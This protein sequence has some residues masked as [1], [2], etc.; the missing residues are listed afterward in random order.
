MEESVDIARL[1]PSVVVFECDGRCADYADAAPQGE[2]AGMRPPEN[3]RLTVQEFPAKR[4]KK[5]H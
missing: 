2:P 3:H 5:N 4:P 1:R